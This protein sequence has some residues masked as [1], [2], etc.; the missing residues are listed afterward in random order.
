MAVDLIR[1]NNEILF[2]GSGREVLDG[3]VTETINQTNF[4]EDHKMY[5][6]KL[7]YSDTTLLNPDQKFS[8]KNPNGGL[9]GIT[10]K[11]IK[12]QREFTFWPKKGMS[13]R[14]VW[15]K[16]SMSYLMT[17]WTRKATNLQG[18]PDAIMAELADVAEQSRDLVN[19]YDITFAEEKVKV[20]TLGFGVTTAEWPWS[21]SARDGLSLFNA[22]HELRDGGT[23]SNIVTGALYTDIA[24]GTTQL[25]AMID[26][27]KTVKMD[28]NKKIKQPKAYKLYCSRARSVFWKQVLNDNSE[29]SGQG[30]N[31]NELN[32]F[33]FKG[34]LV[35]LVIL[36]LL[37]DADVD[38]N[39]IGTDDMVFLSNPMYVN[40]AKALRC[41]NLYEPRLKV[42]E[43]DETD[44]MNTSIRAIIGAGHY[45]AEFGI[46]WAQNV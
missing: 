1:L 19:G 45:D 43:N 30:E 18:A 44:V 15:E 32:Q 22:A 20:L 21:A 7:D 33:N 35:E 11:G 23:F 29:Y 10:E 13:Q 24:T 14:E 4:V 40:E 6:A 41:A 9:R 8:S 27:L 46:V 31:A 38:G 3:T 16:F 2:E 36:D 37:G 42:W 12:P 28:N 26:L 17:Q 34:N 25:Q 39:I 5:G